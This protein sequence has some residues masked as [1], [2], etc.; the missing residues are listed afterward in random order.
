MKKIEI[1]WT[2]TNLN[3]LHGIVKISKSNGE[4]IGQWKIIVSATSTHSESIE[5]HLRTLPPIC[6]DVKLME[7][8]EKIAKIYW[9]G[10]FH[11]M[12]IHSWI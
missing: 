3:E 12:E 5:P 9:Y 2:A 11:Y 8:V 6:A 10:H 4:L 1:K 7:E